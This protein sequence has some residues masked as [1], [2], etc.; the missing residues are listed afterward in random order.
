MPDVDGYETKVEAQE[1]LVPNKRRKHSNKGW[2]IDLDAEL[3]ENYH[4]HIDKA[5]IK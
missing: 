3:F 4:G 5:S 1:K 2:I